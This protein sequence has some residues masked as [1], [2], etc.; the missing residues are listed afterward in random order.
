VL[1]LVR[2]LAL[3][4]GDMHTQG[5][6]HGE[7]TADLI[8]LDPSHAAILDRP[9]AGAILNL[10]GDCSGLLSDLSRL[11]PIRLPTTI[12]ILAREF[13][14][15]G[16][17]LDPRQIDICQLGAVWCRALT[18]EPP[19]AYL[20]SPRVTGRVP[21]ELR[22]VLERTLGANGRARFS[23]AYELALELRSL[24]G[25]VAAPPTIRADQGPIAASEAATPMPK[26][27]S[28]TTPSFVSSGN[29]EDDTSLYNAPPREIAA[30]SASSDPGLPFARLGHYEIVRKIGRGGMGDVYLG[31]EA[32]LDRHVAIKVLPA[33]LA[34]S[35]DFVRRFRTEATAVA[36]LNH[37]NIVPIHFIGED[38]GHHFYVMQYVEGESLAE[39]LDRVKHMGAVE[40]LTIVEQALAGL[41]AAHERGMVHRDI[42]PGNILLD[43]RSGRALLADF[44]LVKSLESAVS[45][46]TATGVVMG[47]VDYISPEQGRGRAVD[48]RSDLYSIGV[49][50]FRMLSGHLPFTADSPTALIFQHV[51]E[52]PPELAAVVADVPTDLAQVVSRLLAKSPS[53]R[54]QTTSELIDDLHT[55]RVGQPLAS[56]PIRAPTATPTV[57]VRLPTFDDDPP[58]ITGLTG[59]AP[60]APKWW[61]QARDRAVSIFRR[62][63]PEALLALQNTQQQVDGAVAVYER[64]QRELQKLADTGESVL[65]ELNAQAHAQRAA[66]RQADQ[67]AA[68]AGEPV[69]RERARDDQSACARAADELER[70]AA[71]QRE[72]LGSIRLRLA[73]ARARVQE[74]QNQRDILNARLLAA[75]AGR[76]VA[77]GGKPRATNWI[78]KTALRV[79]LV[80][81]V[82]PAV[83]WLTMKIIAPPVTSDSASSSTGGDWPP[84]AIGYRAPLA[85]ETAQPTGREALVAPTS[86][87]RQ[88]STNEK[89]VK[90]VALSRDGLLMAVSRHAPPGRFG[91][92]A[93]STQAADEIKLW[94]LAQ[95]SEVLSF[96]E[97][98]HALRMAISPDGL[99]LLSAGKGAKT[100]TGEFK[101]WSLK[102]GK[103][104]QRREMGTESDDGSV[105]FSLDGRKAYLLLGGGVK[106]DLGL[107]DIAAG[108]LDRMNAAPQPHDQI[109][110]VAISPI[111]DIA[112]V[113]IVVTNA[114]GRVGLDIYDL[115]TRKMINNIVPDSYARQLVFSAD[116]RRLVGSTLG[117]VTAWETTEWTKVADIAAGSYY[118]RLA[119]TAEGRYVAGLVD[120]KVEILD[121]E[122]KKLSF[123]STP[124]KCLDIA[125]SPGGTLIVVS[126]EARFAYFDPATLKER[127]TPKLKG[128]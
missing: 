68:A 1:T 45:G 6:V 125:F 115:K 116:G 3:H 65:L 14:S 33:D 109:S 117:K 51:Y 90:H 7:I 127:L 70:Q 86:A 105:G 112:A 100:G 75:R 71:D 2:E 108:D 78:G 98:H 83:F 72:E 41:N 13:Q 106:T 37:P 5:I 64:R 93:G 24:A 8:R 46:K 124:Y 56:A 28:D 32:S 96:D 39:R 50:L 47:T 121:F 62:N 52:Q 118:T 80:V 22:V 55:I 111:R 94:N 36:K 101:I 49:L 69:E 26:S 9:A 73:Q 21:A 76:H 40:T 34:R 30:P 110:T 59:G 107:F 63:A 11:P 91:I 88:Y 103:V 77:T 17:E 89:L 74:L 128:D 102:T 53:D 92:S 29:P 66:A 97:P 35:D 126:D 58:E 104:V 25:Q 57:I 60:Q 44:G 20:R 99:H 42:K 120:E 81:A 4:L 114:G 113:S 122:T 84:G 12:E 15:V 43:S 31:Y 54:Y 16:I 87:V 61:D 85:S 19:A 27:E 10:D 82:G 119:V 48:H 67:R 38:L 79:A 95:G 23:D 123:L 18:G